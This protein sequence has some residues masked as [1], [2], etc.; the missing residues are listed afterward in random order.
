MTAADAGS[1]KPKRR[2]GE[3]DASVK[4]SARYSVTLRAQQCCD[5]ELCD[6]ALLYPP[7]LAVRPLSVLER[8]ERARRRRVRFHLFVF[9]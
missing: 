4:W 1:R 9:T 2:A 5:A 7:R 6:A 8:D 3:R